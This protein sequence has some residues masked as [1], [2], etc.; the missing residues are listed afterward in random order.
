MQGKAGQAS[1]KGGKE[2]VKGSRVPAQS[3]KCASRHTG[4]RNAI[5]GVGAVGRVE[6]CLA[7]EVQASEKKDTTT[8]EQMRPDCQAKPSALE[9]MKDER[10]EA[11]FLLLD[12]RGE[13]LV[14]LPS[15]DLVG[16]LKDREV[17]QL[18]GDALSVYSSTAAA[19]GY[20]EL[21]TVGDFKRACFDY[22]ASNGLH[23]TRKTIPWKTIL[24]YEKASAMVMPG[25][26]NRA[27]QAFQQ[28]SS[29]QQEGA[30]QHEWPRDVDARNR[31]RPA[32]VPALDLT[33][34]SSAVG[35]ALYAIVDVITRKLPCPV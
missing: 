25:A 3:P 16:C 6:G 1:C 21:I 7:T 15:T 4:V 17:A 20:G 35:F 27:L 28:E 13:G 23:A 31:L 14:H 24:A 19:T 26:A 8:F 22:F 33:Q 30:P 5:P 11:I 10:L 2:G 18:V 12:T 32:L 29:W 9:I 34:T